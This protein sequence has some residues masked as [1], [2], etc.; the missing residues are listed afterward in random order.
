VDDD[1][2]CAAVAAFGAR[3]ATALGAS[4]TLVHAGTDEDRAERVRRRCRASA[5][6][7]GVPIVTA[8]DV[9]PEHLHRWAADRGDDLLVVGPPRRGALGSA[10]LG[11]VAHAAARDGRLP[12]VVVPNAGGHAPAAGRAA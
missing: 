12:V 3:L 4:V 1:D 9:D 8:P 2:A 5:P 7:D 6:G 11:S 10:V